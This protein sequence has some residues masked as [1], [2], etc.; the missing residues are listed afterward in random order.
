MVKARKTCEEAGTARA[1]K[2]PPDAL[3]PK[4]RHF[5][6]IAEHWLARDIKTAFREDMLELYFAISG[7]LRMAEQYDDS[8]VTCYEKI[9]KDLKVKL[10][11]IDASGHLRKVLNRCRTAVFFSATMTP[12]NY[13]HKIL[14]C[15]DDAGHFSLPSPFPGHNFDLFVSRRVS[16]LYRQ[17]EKTKA[18]VCR[19]IRTFIEQKRGNY[20]VFFPSY[21]YMMMAHDLFK[22]STGGAEI[23]L[24]TPEMAES[25]R[26]LFLERFSHDNRKTLVGFAVMGGI[27]GEGIDLVG[28]RLCG[29]AIVG[30]GL[31][32]ISLER[33]LIREYFQ[34]TLNA[35]F[36]YAYL[37]PGINRVLQAAGRVI[38]TENDRGAVL[39]IDQR[40]G[41]Y[42]YKSLL[43][44]EWKPIPL[45]NEQQLAEGLQRFWNAGLVK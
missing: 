36:E 10:F 38:R 23:I 35:G 26:E 34:K 14:G 21:A 15:K 3:Y 8:Y 6:K 31:P 2:P 9:N 4:L 45:Q 29:A 7:F 18:E 27:F 30:V 17:R 13:F 39:L 5:L 37:Y 40:Y 41:T 16:T 28:E 24:Q 42:R 19:L 1:E 32:G 20:L 33:D 44:R 25:E 22:D 11:C 12:M 43:P